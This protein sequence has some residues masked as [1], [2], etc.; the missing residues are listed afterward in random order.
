MQ[1]HK[2]S[3]YRAGLNPTQRG[4]KMARVRGI[5]EVTVQSG[6]TLVI[7]INSDP[8]AYII[9]EP[10]FDSENQDQKETDFTE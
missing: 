8:E 1:Q 6:A 7:N 4:V 5:G 2:A 10:N 9:D 3:S